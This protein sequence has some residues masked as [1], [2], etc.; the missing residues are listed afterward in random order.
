MKATGLF[1]ILTVF[2]IG[3]KRECIQSD[4]CDLVPETGLCRA[5]FTKYYF[6]KDVGKCK[7]FTWGGCDGVVPFDTLEEC[8]DCECND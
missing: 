4:K 3:C 5:S 1:L 6:D 7:E 8:E 2:L